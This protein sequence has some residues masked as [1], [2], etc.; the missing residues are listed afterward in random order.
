MGKAL[1]II[2]L[3]SLVAI[4]IM[5]AMVMTSFDHRE[6]VQLQ[7][8]VLATKTAES[9]SSPTTNNLDDAVDL[10]DDSAFPEESN[11]SD[12]LLDVRRGEDS[13]PR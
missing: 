7:R 2:S 4:V 9:R 1:A 6:E 8:D 10:P 11:D 3:I 13:S 5:A 12:D